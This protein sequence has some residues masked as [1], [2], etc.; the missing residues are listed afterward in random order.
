MNRRIGLA[1]FSAFA[2]VGLLFL[3]YFQLHGQARRLITRPIDEN[4]LV[5]LAGNTRPQANEAN[6]RGP[7]ADSM[8]MD[9]L[10]LQLKRPADKEQALDQLI[11]QQ[12]DKTSPNY[13]KWLTADQVGEQFG[14]AKEDIA[15]VTRWLESHGFTIDGVYPHGIVI[16]FSGTAGQV[17][18]AFHTEIH[19]LE[20][21]GERHI[22]NMSDPQIPEAL[23]PAVAGVVSLTNFMP[24]PTLLKRT[25]YSLGNC[26]VASQTF[27][28][29]AVV[30]GDLATIYNFNPLFS[31]GISGQGQ[32]IVVIEDTDVYATGDWSIFRKTFGL[33]RA[34]PYGT[35]TQIHPVQ[36]TGSVGGRAAAVCTPPGSNSD[37][38]EAILDA[39]WASAA[40]PNA[41][42]VLASC[43]DTSNF[44]GFIALQNL[45]TNGVG[46]GG[47]VLPGVVSI[48][49]GDSEPY[50]GATQNAYIS[51]LYQLAASEGVSVFVSSGD[52]GAASSDANA[53]Y[54]THGITVSGF[55]STPYN[56]AVGGTDFGDTSAG[57]VSSYWS[58]TNG[59]NYNSALSYVP[60]I[61]WNDSCASV[62][63]AKY[64]TGSVQ[65]YGA[66]GF[67]N[68]P[69]GSPYQTTASGS[70]GPSNCATGTPSISGV[71]SGTCAGYAKPSWQSGLVGVPTDSVRD[72]P[73]VSLFAANGIW[74]HYYV[75]CWSD[76]RFTSSG[77]TVCTGAPNTWSGFGGT[78]VSSPIMAGIQALIN[79]KVGILNQGL[80]NPT[81]YSL[82]K[83]EYG[84]S[85]NSS[86]N[87]SNGNTIGSSCIFN[88]VTLGDMDV[89]CTTANNCYRPSGTYGVLSTSNSSYTPAYGTAVGWDF[90]T[91]IG[92]VNAYNLVMNWP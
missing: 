38:G 65:T 10:W 42:I 74:G 46:I 79:Q 43:A 35:F 61:P 27:E 70:G 60:E 81:Y 76:P 23:A 13:H 1:L 22:A 73:D 40:A 36:G 2:A 92:T 63:I 71:D 8:R 12:S 57:T 7:V 77:S 4:K 72:I 37:D 50:V 15:T 52:E 58:T 19:H 9:H 45:L 20:V 28:C 24:R 67:C 54:A 62:L 84:A 41:A 85:G 55:A 33:A 53:S 49:Y 86:C 11:Q 80:V 5:R 90:S 47:G 6:D 82:A 48:S 17:R 87:S 39:E 16:E 89:P 18:R 68:S 14:P 88:D 66:G 51:A 78:S 83:T 44:G 59:A 64:V 91:G 21:D 56:M 75:V 25:D 34:Y 26:T 32:T 31:A 69:K 29:Q 30:P 3:T